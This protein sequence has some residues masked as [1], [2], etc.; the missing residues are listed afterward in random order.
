LLTSTPLT[1]LSMPT[2][3]QLS[4][5]SLPTASS[6]DGKGLDPATSNYAISTLTR[7]LAVSSTISS[8]TTTSVA[9]VLGQNAATT[10]STLAPVITDAGNH[11][12][13]PTAQHVLISAA[14]IGTMSQNF[15]MI[16][17]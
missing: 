6:Q 2:N 1:T 7:S 13:S 8:H 16:E 17:F 9:A 4:L 5:S 3:T 12:L 11:S 15:T 10:S 14:T